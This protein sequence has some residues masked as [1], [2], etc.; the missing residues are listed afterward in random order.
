M[1]SPSCYGSNEQVT[2]YN[3]RRDK[4]S[5]QV[6]GGLTLNNII[7]DSSDSIIYSKEVIFIYYY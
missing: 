4:F 5:L 2:V 1:P 7:F 3:K 6:S